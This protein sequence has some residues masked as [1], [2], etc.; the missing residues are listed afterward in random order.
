MEC[1]ESLDEAHAGTSPTST[2]S[3]LPPGTARFGSSSPWQAATGAATMLTQMNQR[4]GRI[5][6]R[7]R[8]SWWNVPAR[9]KRG[10]ASALSSQIRKKAAAEARYARPPGIHMMSPASC[11]SSSGV[12][13][14]SE[15]AAD[16]TPYR[17]RPAKVSNAPSRPLGSPAVNR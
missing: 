2:L 14:H 6:S 8:R 15:A 12:S 17:G 9:P 11:W 3:E 10:A 5:A 7:L 4:S 13:P 16:C 1:T